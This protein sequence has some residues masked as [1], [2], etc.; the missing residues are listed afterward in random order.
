MWRGEFHK[1]R[2]WA[3]PLPLLTAAYEKQYTRFSACGGYGLLF[4]L[5]CLYGGWIWSGEVIK[6]YSRSQT[7]WPPFSTPGKNCQWISRMVGYS[8][9]LLPP[10]EMEKVH[11]APGEVEGISDCFMMGSDTAPR[12]KVSPHVWRCHRYKCLLDGTTMTDPELCVEKEYLLKDTF[13]LVNKGSS[14]GENLN[15]Y[16]ICSEWTVFH[17]EGVNMRLMT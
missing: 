11:A 12:S 10:W 9:L 17:R 3:E 15:A 4:F 1:R 13:V 6:F 7:G 8:A 5:E 2:D 14:Q 16:V